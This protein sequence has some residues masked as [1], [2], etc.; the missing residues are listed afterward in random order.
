MAEGANLNFLISNDEPVL[1]SSQQ[2]LASQQS[3]GGSAGARGHAGDFGGVCEICPLSKHV[4]K[5]YCQAH[6]RAFV[7]IQKVAFKPPPGLEAKAKQKAKRKAERTKERA[8]RG[9]SSKAKKKK[10]KGDVSSSSKSSNESSSIEN[11]KEHMAFMEVFGKGKGHRGQP[12]LARKVLLDFCEKYGD[13]AE[14]AKSTKKRGAGFSLSSYIESKGARQAKRQR[15]TRPKMDYEMFCTQLGNL[16]KW[17]GHKA[18]A[19]WQKLDTKEIMR[20]MMV[21]PLSPD[22]YA[23]PPI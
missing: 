20:M 2:Q 4:K 12:M 9:R 1:G 19:E 21:R 15:R 14:D 10:Q 3:G 7:V 18:D 23:Y 17:D 11:S 13:S 6:Q 8:R 16:R 5:R 22:V